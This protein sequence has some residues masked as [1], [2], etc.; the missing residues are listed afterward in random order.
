PPRTE[1]QLEARSLA[2]VVERPAAC[3]A[4]GGA[5]AGLSA[6]RLRSGSRRQAPG[7]CAPAP[8]ATRSRAPPEAR[9][10]AIDREQSRAARAESRSRTPAPRRSNEDAVGRGTPRPKPCTPPRA[11]P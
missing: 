9:G 10:S 11:R 3:R 1:E 6:R 8:A 4:G 2:P 5:A 7:R